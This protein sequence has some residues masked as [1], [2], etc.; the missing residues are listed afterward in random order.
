MPAHHSDVPMLCRLDQVQVVGQLVRAWVQSESRLLRVSEV[1][2]LQ[3]LQQLF[4]ALCLF[5]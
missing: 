3:Q 1:D 5:P 4:V 2:E